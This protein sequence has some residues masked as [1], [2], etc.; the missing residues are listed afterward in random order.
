M[1]QSVRNKLRNVVTQCR[2]LLEEATAETLQGHFGIY[3]AGKKGLV[4]IDSEASMSHLNDE[5]LSCRHDLIDHLKHIEALGYKQKDALDQLVREISF[6]HLNRLCAYKMMEA[7]GL[8]REAVSRGL[9]SQGFMFYL[10]DHPEDEKLHNSGKQDEAYRHFFDWLGG[11][12]SE[13]IGVLFNP[14]DSA[15]R[16]YP[17]QRVL[18]EVLRLIND[19]ELNGI[20]SQDET[21]GWVYQYFTPKE[22]RDKARKESQAPRNSYELAFRNQ[23]F[24][25]RYVVEFLTDNTLGRIWYEMRKGETTISERCQYL[26]R[27]PTEILLEPGQQPPE[28]VGKTKDD[29]SQDELLKQPV[30]VAHRPKKDPREI[31]ILDPAC[32]SGHFLLYCFDLLQVI[33]EEAWADSDTPKPKDTIGPDGKSS[34]RKLA[35]DYETLEDLRRAIPG[36]ILKH[37]LHGI[38]IDLRAT[39]IAALALWLRCQRAYQDLGLENGKRPKITRSNFVCAEPMP[40]ETD[41]LKEFTATLSPKV[42]GQLV[43]L[44]FEKMKL[45][46]EAGSL[47]KI[48]EEIRDAVATAKGQW[49][50]GPKVEQEE[51]FTELKKPR[52]EQVQLF[53]VSDVTDERFWEQAEDRILGE[54]QDYSEQAVNGKG[55]RRQ[56]FAED[57]ARGFAFVDTCRKK[58]DVLLMNPPYGD[59]TGATLPFAKG[60]YRGHSGN[61]YSAFWLRASQLS[62]AFIGALTSR[63]FLTLGQFG[64]TRELLLSDHTSLCAV[65]DLGSGVLDDAAVET[66]ASIVTVGKLACSEHVFFFDMN[67]EPRGV[68]LR[69]ALKSFRSGEAFNRTF[70][71]SRSVFSGVSGKRMLYAAPMRLIRLFLSD[72]QFEGGL[73]DVRPGLCSGDDFRF[74]SLWW[75]PPVSVEHRKR[76]KP[77]AKGG[78]YERYYAD[79]HFLIDWEHN[80]QKV[81]EYAKEKVGSVSKWVFNESYYFRPGITFPNSSAIG[82]SARCLPKESII[83]VKGQGI[84]PIDPANT[85]FCLALLNS[86]LVHNLLGMVN[87]GKDVQAGDIKILPFSRTCRDSESAVVT[88]MKKLISHLMRI[89]ALDETSPCF[90]APSD[91]PVEEW[92]GGCSSQL[93]RDLESHVPRIGALED[94]VERIILVGYGISEEEIGTRGADRPTV[95]AFVGHALSQICQDGAAVAMWLSYAVGCSYGR[96][97]VSRTVTGNTHGDDRDPFEEQT[98]CPPGMLQGP[99]GLSAKPEDVPLDYPI[100]IDWDGILVDDTEHE[101]DIV[102]RIRDVLEV[103]WNERAEATEKEACEILGVRELRNYFRK[104]GSGGFWMDHV[105]RYSKSSRKAPIYWYLR[106]AKGNYGLWLY[107]H[108]LDKDILFKAL[109]NYVEPKTRLEEDRLNTF[110]SRKES[111]GSA[112]REAK[113]LEKD[114]DRQEQFLSEL[115][116]FGEKL[117]RAADLH[118]AP[119]LNDGV[120]LNIAPLHELVPW[121]EAE[122]YWNELMDGKYE[123]STIGKQLR[124]KG[125][126]K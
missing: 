61:I 4:T 119:D 37:N 122:K 90:V 100:R 17:P 92:Q 53:D 112:G 105:K 109:L 110:R 22:L 36:L 18:D 67:E 34:A 81:K 74:T 39:Q 40:G 38:D 94:E 27:R 115:R 12:L 43:V 88:P 86:R 69:D 7:R 25:P 113:Q 33:Y 65:A 77:F 83:S 24:T 3:A 95:A 108:R 47:L 76:W 15:N 91:A 120:V 5:D 99:D 52:A 84:Y 30:Y 70:C 19:A 116:D 125:L 50:K 16:I 107:Y 98:M 121:N 89:H 103:I 42:L 71:H 85:Y 66:C 87:P 23:F 93:R 26:V 118:L 51:L 64:N 45:A 58:Y 126:V 1:D 79:L 111:V 106:S 101:D 48:E 44:V 63:T 72:H 59:F 56:L 117:R 2:K 55:F 11:T 54:L 80:G 82:F 20:W 73:A 32:G 31:K 21:I 78:E 75:E 35:E 102:R 60:H 114:I 49:Q 29:L 123:W 124:D 62:L 14:N 13:E 10:A 46:G 28:K 104:P 41:M 96:W 68:S 9:K 57:A 6:T 8:M 97:D